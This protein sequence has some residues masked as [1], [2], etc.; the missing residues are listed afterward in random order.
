[1]SADS[2]KKLKEKY[3]TAAE[4]KAFLDKVEKAGNDY[5]KAAAQVKTAMEEKKKEED[6]AQPQEPEEFKQNGNLSNYCART[7]FV[8]SFEVDACR[9]M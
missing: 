6:A 4:L 8:I 5:T 3:T 1:M 7:S 2:L 9:S